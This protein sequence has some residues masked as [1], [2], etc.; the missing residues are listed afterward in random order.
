[1][2]GADHARHIV[3]DRPAQDGPGHDPEEDHRPEHSAHERAEDGAGPG[4]VQQLD[5]ERPAGLQGHAV[6]AV[7]DGQGR[8]L[9][10]IGAE[11]LLHHPA[12][13]Q[14]ARQ[15]NDQGQDQ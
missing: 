1:M 8:G 5:E 10:I 15:K 3:V 9:P 11:D 12:I 14:V 6:H 13:D 7:M 4:Y 2:A